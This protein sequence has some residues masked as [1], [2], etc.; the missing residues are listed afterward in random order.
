M[1]YKAELSSLP[2][3]TKLM[4]KG[5]K[6]IPA[7][8]SAFLFLA[9]LFFLFLLTPVQAAEP[10][11]R[12]RYLNGSG[13]EIQLRINVAGQAPSTLIVTQ[14]LP[15]GT[16]IESASPPF[17]QY[18]AGKGEAKWLLTH[19]SPGEYTLNLRLQTPLASGRISGEIRY[20]DPGSGR[21]TN[22]P[23]RP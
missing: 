20:K 11:V 16:V 15:S 1:P 19:V 6:R 14:N 23:V 12:G 13:R 21:M 3:K 4:P 8:S 2:A 5:Y 17:S 18:D 10:L 7:R 9:M 22:L